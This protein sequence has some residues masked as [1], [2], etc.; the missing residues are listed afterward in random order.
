[1]EMNDDA[2]KIAEKL[3]QRDHHR[4]AVMDKEE[5]KG[6]VTQSGE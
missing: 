2:A 6:V 4:V 1:M 5:F 3:S